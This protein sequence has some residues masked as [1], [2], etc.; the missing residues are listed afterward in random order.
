MPKTTRHPLRFARVTTDGATDMRLL[1]PVILAVAWAAPQV[2]AQPGTFTLHDA[3][4]AVWAR[5]PQ[6]RT[7]EARQL[8]AAARY[9]SG[10]AL[11]PNAPTATGNFVDDKIIGSNYDYI[12]SEVELSTPVWLPGEGTATQTAATAEG[13]A[14]LADRDALHLAVAEKVLQLVEQAQDNMNS[15]AVATRREDVAASLAKSVRQRFSLGEAPETDALAAD[16]EAANAEVSLDAVR[17]QAESALA[18]YGALTGFQRLPQL[19]AKAVAAT[20]CPLAAAMASGEI[21]PADQAMLEGNPRIVAARRAVDA[22][23]AK[24]RLVRIEDRDNPEI[25]LQG[26]DEK[27]P[28]TRWDTRM[29]VIIRVPFASAARN[30]PRRAA[31]EQAVTEAEVQLELARRDVLSALCQSDA[32]LSAVERAQLASVRA[33]A[34]LDQ[35]RGKIERAWRAGETPL[36]E[37]IRADAGAFDADLAR[38]KASL[39]LAVLRLRAQLLRGTLP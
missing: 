3:V 32:A 34:S 30:A 23:R 35:R 10:G 18:A 12:T 31:A 8:V 20:P 16:A 7:I 25:G 9:A 36:V 6:L 4:A 11:F 19:S 22:A 29:A 27:Q 28:G 38:D 17:A 5:L 33:A 2:R 37:V 26:I 15:L 24:A 1:I 39:S 13:Q 21:A 14:I